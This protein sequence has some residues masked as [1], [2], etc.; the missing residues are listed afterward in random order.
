[1][2]LA[3]STFTTLLL[4]AY[5][6]LSSTALVFR[7]LSAELSCKMNEFTC[8]LYMKNLEIQLYIY[9]ESNQVLLHRLLLLREVGHFLGGLWGLGWQSLQEVSYWL[10]LLHGPKRGC[11]Q[12]WS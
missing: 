12:D 4:L 1:M 3:R 8:I 6:R 10:S 7:Q 9:D 5:R 2:P 11:I